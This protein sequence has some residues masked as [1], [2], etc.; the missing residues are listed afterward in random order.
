[1][2]L[3]LKIGLLLCTMLVPP[4]VIAASFHSL[5]G[6]WYVGIDTVTYKGS[7]YNVVAIL[8]LPSSSSGFGRLAR[9]RYEHLDDFPVAVLSYL[10][11]RVEDH[12]AGSLGDAATDSIKGEPD[13]ASAGSRVVFVT[14]YNNLADLKAMIRFS[15]RVP[16]R[17]DSAVGVEAPTDAEARISELVGHEVRVKRPEL[18]FPDRTLQPPDEEYTGDVLEIKSFCN[19]KSCG[20]DFIPLVFWGAKNSGFLKT[21]F[22]HVF[23]PEYGENVVV[24]PETFIIESLEGT[25]KMYLGLGFKLERSF[26]E[27]GLHLLSISR[28]DFEKIT[29]EKLIHGRPGRALLPGNQGEL[30]RYNEGSRVEPKY[31]GDL[32]QLKVSPSI[33]FFHSAPNPFRLL[34]R[35]ACAEQLSELP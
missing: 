27:R 19:F 23:V 28:D 6:D 30:T 5:L 29:L 17:W 33:Q 22:N 7:K 34:A 8:E 1:M 26:P 20:R 4:S 16:T 35:P 25:L 15:R 10:Q 2:G 31:L 24:A 12:Y 14:G 32:D 9:E 18:R 21:G 3:L 11:H 13:F